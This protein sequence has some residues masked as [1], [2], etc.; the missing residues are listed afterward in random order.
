M[1]VIPEKSDNMR[2]SG[3][4]D[5]NSI[6]WNKA[7]ESV[8]KLQARIVKAQR[9]GRHGKV[10]S[11]SRILT[12]SFS[13]KA[14]AVKRVTQN[15]GKFTPGVDGQLWTTSKQRTKAVVE[16][17]PQQYKTKPLRRVYIPKANGKKR[18]LG[19]PTMKD[20]AMQA[21]YLLALEPIAETTA[22]RT[23]Y[24]F[25]RGRST[26]DAIGQ[27]FI[28]LGSKDA[29]Q[30]ILE[31]DIKGCFD[32]ISHDWLLQHI[33]MEKRILRQW[34]K[35]GYVE[36]AKFFNTDDGTPQGGI[37]SPVLANMA[38]DGIERLINER[39]KYLHKINGQI[40]YRSRVGRPTMVH[41]IRYADDFII[42]GASKDLL[43]NEVKPMIEK[44]L[45]E[46]GLVLSKEK[47]V[48]THIEKGFD[49]L[50]FNVRKYGMKLLIK[51]SK[52]GTKRMLDKIRE[53]AKSGR[54]KG[55]NAK[56]LIHRLNPI[57]RGWATYYRHV[58]SK[59]IFAWVDF[60][61]WKCVWSWAISHHSCK[62]KRWIRKRYFVSKGNRQWLFSDTK[63]DKECY[64]F[65]V[66]RI[67]IV[68]HIKIQQN[69][70]P[71]DPYWWSY[72]EKRQKKKVFCPFK[73]IKLVTVPGVSYTTPQEEA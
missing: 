38:L 35:A 27:S 56:T 15:K 37:I 70:N 68:R 47:T 39:Y 18:P 11:L 51:P 41:F 73:R 50:G 26:A 6:D 10:R 4:L 46:R 42:T 20:R 8:R 33:P 44:F 48:I 19:I 32:N 40:Y 1:N 63:S 45:I 13:A 72:F 66:A 71:F 22:D 55:G 64:L 54:G 3:N 9:E 14:L 7:E 69:A 60:Q 29:P 31:G 43:Q 62:G 57:L 30:W 12:R 52:K 58:V 21:L 17:N 53:I 28:V 67:K 59:R 23:S 25:R 24:G 5:W 36:K 61:V 34:L 65:S 2:V 49:F 16:L